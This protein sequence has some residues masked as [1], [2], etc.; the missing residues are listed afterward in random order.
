MQ[1]APAPGGEKVAAAAGL[2]GT[3]ADQ[4]EEG[5][6][7]PKQVEA[8]LQ[9]APRPASLADEA[10]LGRQSVLRVEIALRLG[11]PL[12]GQPGLSGSMVAG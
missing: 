8:S 1:T 10:A 11:Q 5:T 9:A 12:L 2:V 7:A 4:C 3:A 6:E